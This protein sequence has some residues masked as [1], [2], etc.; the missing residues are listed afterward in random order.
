MKILVL[1]LGSTSSKVGLFENQQ[2]LAQATLRHERQQ[3]EAFQNIIDQKAFRQAAI[4]DWLQGQG[5]GL[6][7]ID[8]LA[9]RGG[10]LRPLPGG[11][12][13]VCRVAAADA[14]SGKY[15]KHP[16]N[17]GILIAAQWQEE[18]GIPALF[19]DAPTTDELDAKARISGLS[20]HTRH[21]VFHAL[22]IKRVARLYCQSAKIPEADSRLIVAHMGG[23][24]SV[25]ALK[26]M[27]AIDVNSAI[28][29]EGPFTPERCGSLQA[30]TVLNLVDEMG[31]DT[32]AVY[33]RIY[34]RGG[35]YSYFGSNHVGQLSKQAR[36]ENNGEIRLVLDAMFYQIA[37][38]IAGLAISLK[39]R[40]D[41]ILL[42]GGVAYNQE[43]MQT[44]SQMLRFIAPVTVY[45]GEDELAALAE[46][47][48]RV[49]SGEEEVRSI[50]A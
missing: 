18:H 34:R 17:L 9:V 37:K 23:G 49:L 24:I 20:G 40:V 4:L 29:G 27:K 16:A 10:L 30:Y 47:A 38:A 21:C 7:D 26:G 1:N 11:S 15:G 22:N 5:L 8:A 46:G 43:E 33:Q 2:Q 50:E 36:E 13:R 45:P 19:T 48:W 3:I 31:G 41:Q 28:D 35:L 44:L 14:A 12:Y 6:L 39:G 42:T 32:N 25:C